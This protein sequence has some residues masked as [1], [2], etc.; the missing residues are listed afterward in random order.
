M[1]ILGVLR[2]EVSKTILTLLFIAAHVCGDPLSRYT[3]RAT[4][5]AAG[6]LRILGF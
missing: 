2:K 1:I 5:V 3:C 6:F 4:H